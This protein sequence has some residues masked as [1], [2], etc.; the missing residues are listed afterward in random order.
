MKNKKLLKRIKRLERKYEVIREALGI[1]QI[2]IAVLQD[3]KLL[4]KRWKRILSHAGDW[5]DERPETVQELKDWFEAGQPSEE[6]EIP[7]EPIDLLKEM[8]KMA[9]RIKELE[10]ENKY[11]KSQINPYVHFYPPYC[12]TSDQ[13][14]IFFIECTHNTKKEE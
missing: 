7:D 3:D 11:L 12:G 5:E 9:D 8:H 4:A 10:E 13:P 6:L 2:H 1:A 14:L